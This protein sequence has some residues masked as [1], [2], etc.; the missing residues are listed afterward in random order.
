MPHGL[1]FVACHLAHNSFLSTL[2]WTKKVGRE[3]DRARREHW[4]VNAR[5]DGTCVTFPKTSCTKKAVFV[6]LGLEFV[7]WV[8][9]YYLHRHGQR[10]PS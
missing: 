1:E 8:T 6:P 2:T 10:K 9:T 5:V 3:Q 7:T 4:L